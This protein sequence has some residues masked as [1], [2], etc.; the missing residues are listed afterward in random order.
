M[1]LL[2]DTTNQLSKFRAINFVCIIINMFFL[3][4]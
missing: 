3:E 1:E 2:D 4:E